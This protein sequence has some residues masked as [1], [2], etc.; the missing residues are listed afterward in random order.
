MGSFSFDGDFTT[1]FC[2]ATG[3]NN[4][5]MLKLLLFEHEYFIYDNYFCV[6][7]G[8][9]DFIML[10]LSRFEHVNL[11]NLLPA[12]TGWEQGNDP[13]FE[14]DENLSKSINYDCFEPIV[15]I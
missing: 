13:S 15:T 3:T 6:A 14:L 12:C 1:T 11:I 4:L 7:T 2:A 10:K 5:T 9:N 8:T